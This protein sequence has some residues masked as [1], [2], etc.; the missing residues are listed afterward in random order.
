VLTLV[1]GA[2]LVG[3]GGC[4]DARSPQSSASSTTTSA[5]TSTP[6]GALVAQATG[7]V[8]VHAEPDGAVDRTL[9]AAD[10]IGGRLVFLVRRQVAGGWLLVDLPVR[11]NGSTGYIR[12]REVHLSRNRFS[13][14]VELGEHRLEVR[15]DGQPIF[16][17]PA[18][19]GTTATPT[20]GGR[21][22]V[23]ELLR[24]PDPGGAYGP[25]AYG[26]SGF[27]T[28]LSSFAGSDGVV[29]IH[30]TDQPEEVGRDVSHGCIRLRNDD[31]VAL[32]ERI[33]L[34]LGTPVEIGP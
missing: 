11:P 10:E 25:Y 16:E 31:I 13:V 28:T 5:T 23:K 22:Y 24:P 34:P 6:R 7:S 15:R 19:I 26:L 33:R 8:E 4:G 18:G 12:E 30:G 20:P 14:R 9:R 32:A 29:G 2:F 17:A 21:F 1:L 3:A 27:S